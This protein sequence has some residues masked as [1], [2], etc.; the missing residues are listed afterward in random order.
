[1]RTHQISRRRFL[2]LAVATGA[3]IAAPTNAFAAGRI[4]ATTYPGSWEEAHRSHIAALFK[5]KTG[6]DVDVTPMQG[7]DQVAK[8]VASRN[9]PPFDV[10]L[11]PTGPMLQALTQDIL[12]PFPAAKS[13]NYN[14]VPDAFRRPMGPDVSLQIAG[15]A[16][17]PNKIKTPPSSWQALWDPKYKGRVG[18]CSMTSGLGTAFMLEIARM[19]TKNPYNMGPAFD[20]VKTLLPNVSSIANN[21]ATLGALFQQGEVDIA[22]QF[23]NEVEVLRGKGVPVA[24]TRPETGWAVLASGMYIVKNTKEPNLAAAY[25]D[26]ALDPAVQAKLANAP[27]YLVP[28]NRKVSFAGPL[29]VIAKNMDELLTNNQY[30]WEVVN[31]ERPAWIDRFNKEIRL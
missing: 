9:N 27:Y 30:D 31:K 2:S 1:M 6:A 23:L 12:T 4:V 18:L 3:Y 16:Y 29:S 26:A 13:A 7:V 5:Q 28:T 22:P 17:N 19:T 21:P 11:F 10:V 8:I 14:D 24:F 20:A 25:I 15:I